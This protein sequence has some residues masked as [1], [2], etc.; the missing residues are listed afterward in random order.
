MT[1]KTLI[2]QSKKEE[3][4]IIST[5]QESEIDL[6]LHNC[7]LYANYKKKKSFKSISL[8]RSK[9]VSSLSTSTACT[10]LSE[11]KKTKQVSFG[12]INIERVESY[13][14]YN[15]NIARLTIEDMPEPDYSC[16]CLLI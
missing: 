12:K 11:N 15:R 8:V 5:F 1:E 14:K 2:Y 6:S 7:N 4:L 16:H 3:N 13:K 10:L 9:K